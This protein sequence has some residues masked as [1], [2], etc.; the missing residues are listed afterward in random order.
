MELAQ[1]IDEMWES[2]ELDPAVVEE[3]IALLDAGEIRVAEPPTATGSSTS[4]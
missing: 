3:A 1:Q 2:G 4:G